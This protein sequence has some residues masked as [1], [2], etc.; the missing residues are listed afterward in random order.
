MIE[1][2]KFDILVEKVK[3]RFPFQYW[4]LSSYDWLDY[5]K[6]TN[7]E[8]YINY[9][10]NNIYDLV[11]DGKLLYAL[12]GGHWRFFNV[13]MGKIFNDIYKKYKKVGKENICIYE[14]EREVDFDDESGGDLY[15]IELNKL[16]TEIH[17]SL[18]DDIIIL[19]IM[20]NGVKYC[21]KKTM[22]YYHETYGR[23]YGYRDL[24]EWISYIVK[25]KSKYSFCVLINH[26]YGIS[27]SCSPF[28]KADNKIIQEMQEIVLEGYKKMYNY[29]VNEWCKKM[30][31]VTKKSPIELLEMIEIL[32]KLSEIE[33]NKKTRTLEVLMSNMRKYPNIPISEIEKFFYKIKAA[34]GKYIQY[35]EE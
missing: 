26:L 31:E 28:E 10:P 19:E 9:K 23:P 25:D 4:K 35:L 13:C 34:N 33:G 24:E 3:E 15:T 14:I 29:A 1:Q 8:Q 18:T 2:E 6:R 11:V 5:L 7:Q 27:I 32:D 20:I 12:Y 22:Y 30:L 21:V 17:Y 16:P